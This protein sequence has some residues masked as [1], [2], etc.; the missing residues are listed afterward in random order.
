MR[1]FSPH[2]CRF[3]GVLAAACCAALLAACGGGSSGSSSTTTTGTTSTVNNVLAVTV[4]AGPLVN[5]QSVGDAD[6]LFATVTICV[7]GTSTC[8][9][10][11]HMAVDTGSTGIRILA[12]QLSLALPITTSGGVQ[13]GNCIQYADNTYQW[14]PVAQADVQLSGEM[15]SAVPIQV[16]GFNNFAGAPAGCSAGGT[17]VE[18]V[19][20]LGAKGILGLGVFRQDCGVSCASA[21]PP[22]VYYAC[23]SSSCSV[24][25]VSV[26]A[27]LQ[28]PVW[29]FPQDNNGLAVVLPQVGAGGAPSATGS[30]IF[31][32]GTQSNNALG[33]AVAQ[34]ADGLG[35]FTTTYKSVQY[36]ASFIDTGSNGIFFLDAATTGLTDCGANSNE[37]GFYC[38]AAATGFSAINSGP[39]PAG[40][41]LPNAVNVA[42][43]IQNAASLFNSVNTA[44]NDI[45]GDNPG[46]FDWGL[47]FFFGRTVFIGIENQTTPAGLGPYWAY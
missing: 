24:A 26:S 14:G 3:A 37:P 47:P 18:T 44:F 43:S 33:A 8:Q 2:G 15:A 36:T 29:L 12:S 4:D 39:N 46:A 38:P 42:F 1:T 31:G 45:G 28:N 6:V 41:G 25:S 27:Q 23:P 40:S 22:A 13:I 10:I 35:N 20:Q 7:P 16:V 32:I 11:D 17:P 34:A 21:A 9:T 19:Q 30:I 5:G